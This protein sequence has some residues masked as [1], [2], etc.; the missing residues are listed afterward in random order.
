MSHYGGG[1]GGGRYDDRRGGG[2]DRYGG[3]GGDRYGGGGGGYRGGQGG[4]GS[5]DAYR[6]GGGGGDRYGGGGGGRYGGGGGGGY[7]GGGPPRGGGYGGGGGGGGYGGSRY[8]SSRDAGRNWRDRE[9]GGARGGATHLARIHGTE[10]D[11]VNCPFYFKIGAC[12]HGDRCSRQHHK[13][14]FSQTMIVQHMYQNPASRTVWKS[15]S[16]SGAHFSAMTRPRWLRRAVR[17]RHRHAIEQASRRW[18]GGRRDDSGRTR[19]KILI[20]TQVA[21]RGGRRRPVAARPEEGA[22]GVRR[23]LRGGLRRARRLRR[24]RGAQRLRE[25]RRPHGRQRLLQVR[26]RGALGR[27]AQGALRPL[28]R[29]PAARLRVLARDGLPRGA[30]PPVRRGRV[31]ARRLLQL[32]AHPDAVA[33]APQGPREALQEEVAQGAREARAPGARRERVVERR[34]Q[35][36]ALAQPLAQPLARQGQGEGPLALALARQGEG[37]EV[38]PRLPPRGRVTTLLP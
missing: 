22:G 24:D 34:R 32:H 1:G 15:T 17:N 2:G 7:G 29:G 23:V 35:G 12:R 13:P 37:G 25:P 19:R 4:Y 30:L 26:R 36:L 5:N 14:P 16:A 28:L 11:K 21:D 8:D 3:G 6:G 38:A 20:C 33:L 27:G 31:H 18:R 10:E 9:L